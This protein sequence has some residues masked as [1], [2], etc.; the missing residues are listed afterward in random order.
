MMSAKDAAAMR[1]RE[2]KDQQEIQHTTVALTRDALVQALNMA[3]DVM[4]NSAAVAKSDSWQ[5]YY[6]LLMIDYRDI[7]QKVALGAKFAIKG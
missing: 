5:S 7:A 3:A 6:R 2:I 4:Q 1:A